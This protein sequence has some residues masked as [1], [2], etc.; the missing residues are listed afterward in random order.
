MAILIE[1]ISVVVQADAIL[2]AYEGNVEV[3][4][5]AVPNATLCADSELARVGFMHPDDV[6]SFVHV[7]TAAGMRYVVGGEAR[8]IAVV[9]QIRGPM[10][11]APWLEFGHI[12][13]QGDP[14]KRVA[15][16]RLTGSR[17]TKLV[18]PQGWTYERS[19]TLS[20]LVVP[21]EAAETLRFEAMDGNLERI[22][23]PLS[24]RPLYIGRTRK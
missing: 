20:Y 17:I 14:G 24:E 10:I 9:D 21:Q 11:P 16:C 22:R 7:L 12:E 6:E 23:T 2:R 18:T 1:A 15:C 4:K 8:D 13:W 3:F 5:S 19:L